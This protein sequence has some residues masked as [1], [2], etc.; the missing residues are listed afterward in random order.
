MLLNHVVSQ[1]QG[2]LKESNLD[3]WLIYDFQKRNSIGINFLEIPDSAHL[4]RRMIYW[5]PSIGDPIK[6]VSIIEPNHL[7]HLPGSKLQYF[8]WVDFQKLISSILV[9]CKRVAMEFSHH[10][11]IP[12]QSIVDAGFVDLV[13]SFGVEVCS[14]AGF[15]QQFTCVLNEAQRKSHLEAAELLNYLAE[16]AWEYIFRSLRDNL[17]ITEYHVQQRIKEGFVKRG[18]ISQGDPICAVNANSSN[19]HYSPNENCS[20][21]VSKGDFIL[22]DLWCKKL[23]SK[24]VYADITR[25]AVAGGKPSDKQREVFSVVRNAQK[26]AT[27]FVIENMKSHQPV[28]GCDVDKKARMVISEAGYEDFFVHRTGHNIFIE[29]HGPGTHLDS[30]ETCDDRD[31]IPGTCFSIEPGIYL[32]DQFGVRLEYDIL[33][34]RDGSCEITGG[35]Q[36]QIK[37]LF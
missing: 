16:D 19:P 8:S 13:R 26:A 37:L 4:T 28:R 21:L 7:D 12:Y 35:E 29:D 20:A 23:E 5:I 25:V 22:I 31:I 10:C 27:E 3:G 33:T 36:D 1:V 24:A 18:F 32:P 9:N 15:I 17:L 11:S 30:I 34:A 2:L 14:S 6:I